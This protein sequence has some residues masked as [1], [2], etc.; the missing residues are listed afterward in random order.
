ML[1][2][3][4][5]PL[6]VIILRVRVVSLYTQI[7]FGHTWLALL[8]K[9]PQVDGQ[10]AVVLWFTTLSLCQIQLIADVALNETEEERTLKKVPH[11]RPTV[12]ALGFRGRIPLTD[13]PPASQRYLGWT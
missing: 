13:E 6:P 9:R 10:R 8:G 4:N 5:G 2:L 7:Y 1:G 11:L 3:S 12:N